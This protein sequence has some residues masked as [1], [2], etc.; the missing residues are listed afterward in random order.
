MFRIGGDY[1]VGLSSPRNDTTTL[2]YIF[3]INFEFLMDVL[4][5]C[6]VMVLRRADIV[7]RKI[8]RETGENPVQFPLL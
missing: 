6:S 2:N 7:G 5:L 4:Y 8:K 1:H 3:P